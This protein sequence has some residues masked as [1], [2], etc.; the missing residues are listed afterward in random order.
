MS[1][2]LMNARIE[3]FKVGYSTTIEDGRFRAELSFT[4]ELFCTGLVVQL[5]APIYDAERKIIGY[6]VTETGGNI[7]KAIVDIAGVNSIKEV[8]GQYVR[9]ILEGDKDE[10]FNARCVGIMH[11]LNQTWLL[12]YKYRM[13][14]DKALTYNGDWDAYNGD[15][16]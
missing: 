4:C 12:P 13:G 15:E 3:G 9:V 14:E 7:L 11:I 16:Q 5:D 6:S 8:T 2:F 10:M 1:L